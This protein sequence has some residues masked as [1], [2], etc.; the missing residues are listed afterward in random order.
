MMLCAPLKMH[1]LDGAS[2]KITKGECMNEPKSKFQLKAATYA[3][4]HTV[5]ILSMG[6]ARMTFT[7]EQA[8]RDFIARNTVVECK[9]IEI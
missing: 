2:F 6:W 3:D 5:Y 9:T 7:T 1:G 4:G 8:A